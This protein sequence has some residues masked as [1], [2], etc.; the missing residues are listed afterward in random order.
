L[1][2]KLPIIVCDF[3]SNNSIQ[4]TVMGETIGTI[5]SGG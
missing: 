1:E 5:V 4:R 2:N 3:L